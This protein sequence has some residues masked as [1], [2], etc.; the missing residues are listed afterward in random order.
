[1]VSASPFYPIR[2]FTTDKVVDKPT[3]SVTAGTYTPGQTQGVKVTVTGGTGTYRQ[4]LVTLEVKSGATSAKTYVIPGTHLL[5]T[6]AD[7]TG[8]IVL[9]A[10]YRPNETITETVTFT[11]AS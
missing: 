6:G 4:N 7:E 9:K 11:N 8:T 3:L 5:H 2:V 10:I 1:M